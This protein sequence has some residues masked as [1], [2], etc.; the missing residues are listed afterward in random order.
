MN[1][2]E[3]AGQRRVVLRIVAYSSVGVVSGGGSVVVIVSVTESYGAMVSSQRK[4]ISASCVV[5]QY[6]FKQTQIVDIF[7][8]RRQLEFP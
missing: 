3:V 6:L 5:L 1:I 4:L 7:L 8:Q 2:R